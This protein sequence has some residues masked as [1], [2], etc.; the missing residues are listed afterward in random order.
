[1]NKEKELHTGIVVTFQDSGVVELKGDKDGT[2][3]YKE[4]RKYVG[5]GVVTVISFA[6]NIDAW[7]GD[8]G[9]LES[10]NFVNECNIKEP[11]ANIT[12]AGNI[13][14]LGSTPDGDTIGLDESQIAYLSENLTF[15][16]KGFVR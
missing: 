13:L 10:G 2:V 6:H 11:K 5:C 14:F 16:L 12:L 4:I 1:M 9:L 15:G 7:C 3:S 8:E